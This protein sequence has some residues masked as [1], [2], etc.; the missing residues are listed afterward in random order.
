MQVVRAMLLVLA[1]GGAC[2]GASV[3]VDHLAPLQRLLD[4]R[5][6]RG[7]GW[8]VP[9]TVRKQKHQSFLSK[10]MGKSEYRFFEYLLLTRSADQI[11]A[12]LGKC[13]SNELLRPALRRGINRMPCYCHGIEVRVL[14][15]LKIP[16]VLTPLNE[17]LWCR[18]GCDRTITEEELGRV[19]RMMLSCGADPNMQVAGWTSL[20]YAIISDAPLSVMKIL[21]EEGNV[22]VVQLVSLD[23]KM[24][25][26]NNLY[27]SAFAELCFGQDD[28][29][30]VYLKHIEQQ[31]TG[32]HL[33]AG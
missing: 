15:G 14:G 29:R 6:G 25:G 9:Q 32:L 10:N 20:I 28:E 1:T 3:E 22:S 17:L 24:D 33:Q 7:F 27:P 23:F 2:Q 12:F 19:V 11:C 13:N 30:T 16:D 21:V 5:G 31:K 4:Q 26:G 8:F 18:W